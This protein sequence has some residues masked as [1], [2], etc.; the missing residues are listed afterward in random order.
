MVGFELW[1]LTASYKFFRSALDP[2]L[3]SAL[4]VTRTAIDGLH[5]STVVSSLVYGH[6]LGFMAVYVVWLYSLH[7][8]GALKY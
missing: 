3:W 6:A 2:F 4:E 1:L 8:T 5:I 7:L